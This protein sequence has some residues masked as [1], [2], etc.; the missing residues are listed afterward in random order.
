M[1]RIADLLA[2]HGEYI[3][4]LKWYCGAFEARKKVLGKW[5][6]ETLATARTVAFVTGKAGYPKEADR[7]WSEVEQMERYLSGRN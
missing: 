7:W 4:A 2:Q 6:P 3:Y 1:L 5:D